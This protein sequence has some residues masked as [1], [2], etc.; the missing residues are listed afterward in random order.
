MEYMTIRHLLLTK[1]AWFFAAILLAGPPGDAPAAPAAAGPLFCE[2]FESRESVEKIGGRVGP[3]VEFYPGKFGNAACIPAGQEIL[4]PARGRLDLRA[5]TIEYWMRPE[6]LETNHSFRATPGGFRMFNVLSNGF[7][8]G[9]WI[10]HAGA[11]YGAVKEI[12]VRFDENTPGGIRQP[13]CNLSGMCLG[14]RSGEWH[15]VTIA[16]KLAGPPAE[17]RASLFLDDLLQDRIEGLPVG[18]CDMGDWLRFMPGPAAV[19][20]FCV[21]DFPKD[22]PQPEFRNLMVNPGF[23]LDENRDALPDG[24]GQFGPA[25]TGYWGGAPALKREERGINRRVPDQSYSG[26]WSAKMEGWADGV[27]GQVVAAVAGIVPG[28]DYEMDAALRSSI[29]QVKVLFR[30]AGYQGQPLADAAADWSIVIP[31]AGLNRWCL[32]SDIRRGKNIFHAPAGCRQVN[33]YFIMEGQ[34][35]VY[36]DD[37]CFVARKGGGL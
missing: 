20:R 16:Y 28:Q 17:R 35:F 2:E 37:V 22:Y 25:G 10:S 7:L 33:I 36:L 12:G 27:A 29:K 9:I 31:E 8:N 26:R 19:D 23:E 21:Y 6:W 5:G 15:K 30:P 14:W 11:H 18:D 13:D 32:I 24:W 34:G 1:R 4:I 3:G